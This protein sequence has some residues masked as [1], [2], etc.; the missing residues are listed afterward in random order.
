MSSVRVGGTVTRHSRDS[1]QDND[2]IDFCSRC[3]VDSAAAVRVCAKI[4]EFTGAGA[5]A[6]R[7]WWIRVTVLAAV[8]MGQTSPRAMGLDHLQP[9][10]HAAQE[11]E[12]VNEGIF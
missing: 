9:A 6:S 4:K 10:G 3:R 7:Y 8:S 12:R 11:H 2:T 5:T 1:L